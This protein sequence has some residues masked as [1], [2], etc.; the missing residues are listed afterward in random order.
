[1]PAIFGWIAAVLLVGGIFWGVLRLIAKSQ[2]EE[3]SYSEKDSE[4]ITMQKSKDGIKC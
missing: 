4:S 1:M 3:R 2:D